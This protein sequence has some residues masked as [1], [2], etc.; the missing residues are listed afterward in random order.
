MIVRNCK[1]SAPAGVKDGQHYIQFN[2]SAV[3]SYPW[4]VCRAVP[5]GHDYIDAAK[6]EKH[7]RMIAAVANIEAAEGDGADSVTTHENSGD[8]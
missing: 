5:S 8:W 6:T 7:A 4:E 3:A 2:K 1:G